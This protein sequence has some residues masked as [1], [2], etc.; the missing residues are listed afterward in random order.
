MVASID[1]LTAVR[2][3]NRFVIAS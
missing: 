3:T 2:M 1:P